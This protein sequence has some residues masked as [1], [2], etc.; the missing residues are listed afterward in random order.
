M[1]DKKILSKL[2]LKGMG[3]KPANRPENGDGYPLCQM[4]GRATG[5][6]AKEDSQGKVHV[7]IIGQ[8]E[9]I[10]LEDGSVYSSSVMYLPEGIHGMLEDPLTKA[11]QAGRNDLTIEFGFEIESFKSS[12]PIGY[13]YRATALLPAEEV[14][15]L[16]EIRKVIEERKQRLLEGKPGEQRQIAA[17]VNP[18]EQRKASDAALAAAGVGAAPAAK[19]AP[20]TTKR[21]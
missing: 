9:G 2:T 19:P 7:G 12:A 4:F 5:T 1:A 20:A 11:A 16:S 3:C 13:S 18:A 14:D 8:F 17:A 6:K 10:N 15:D 21:K